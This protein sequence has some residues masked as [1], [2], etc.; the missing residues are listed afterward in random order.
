MTYDNTLH[1]TF[2]QSIPFATSFIAGILTFLSPC[3]LPL[4]PPYMSYISSV[5]ISQLQQKDVRRGRIIF[6]SILFILG[7]SLVFL[8]LAMFGSSMLGEFFSSSI[9]RYVA[10][11]VIILFGIHFLFNFKF[12]FLYKHFQLNINHNRFGFLAPFMLGIGFGIGWSPCVGPVLAS[13]LALAIAHPS[14]ALRLMLC[15]CA[16]IGLGFLLV[17]IF[18][19][20]GLRFLK[21]FTPF[22]RVIE[23]ISGILLILIGLLIIIDKTDFLL[24]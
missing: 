15:Y 10:G 4:V 13:I 9:V 12:S 2:Y 18:I 23:V 11:G 14:S 8:T 17:A 1:E 22:M 24:P 7:F 20:S 21:K 5:S 3:M 16:G 6:T 19:N